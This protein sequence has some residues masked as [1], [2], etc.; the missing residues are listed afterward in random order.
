[1]SKN[2]MGDVVERNNEIRRAAKA[3][4]QKNRKGTGQTLFTGS[5]IEAAKR[6][7]Q[8]RERREAAQLRNE[9]RLM[10][11]LGKKG[12]LVLNQPSFLS[13][14]YRRYEIDVADV[15]RAAKK[16]PVK[17]Y[18]TETDSAFI[19]SVEKKATAEAV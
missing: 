13:D 8:Q 1:M 4:Q 2:P 12:T 7:R 5:I 6:D 3:R 15:K 14:E 19:I 9:K 16:S 17:Y 11:E 18:W 10:V